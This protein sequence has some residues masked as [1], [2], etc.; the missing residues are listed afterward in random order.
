MK[1]DER[2]GTVLSFFLI[3][4]REQLEGI[5]NKVERASQSRWNSL[6]IILTLWYWGL[7]N[8]NDPFYTIVDKQWACL[9]KVMERLHVAIRHESVSP[10]ALCKGRQSIGCAPF[11]TLHEM[12]TEKHLRE[13]RALTLH[14]GYCV[15][16]LDGSTQ[17]LISNKALEKAYGRPPSTGKQKSAPQASFVA[18]E[19]LNTGWIAKY[20]LSRWDASELALSKELA[21]DLGFGDLLLADRLYFD[22]VWYVD[23]NRRK[24]KFLFRCNCNRHESLTPES[25]EKIKKLRINGNVDC[26]VDLKVKVGSGRYEILENIRYIEVRRQGVETLY[27]ITNMDE[28]ELT[29]TEAV[30]LYRLR[31]EIETN[32]RF[33]KGQDH[34]PAVRSKKE[35][36]VRQEVLLHVLAHNSVR[37]IQSQACI[38]EAATEASLQC[39]VSTVS[40]DPPATPSAKEVNKD[41]GDAWL[42]KARLHGDLLRPVDLQFYRTVETI[43]GYAMQELLF[44]SSS[45][46][47]WEQLLRKIAGLKI[48]AKPGRSYQRHGRKFNKGKRN[49]GNVKAQR[50]RSGKRKKEGKI[51]SS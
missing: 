35:E 11:V 40:T 43:L 20:R 49:K 21:A 14:K 50:N 3:W 41:D 46:L 48:W 36:T 13:H 18:L 45:T 10:T 17:N 7:R 51:E 32:F 5:A 42:P 47:Q 27:F 39:N 19:L 38:A 9:V 26:R 25:R 31:W 22:P 33:F 1:N 4:S 34:L 12:A 44:P 24:V 29:T 2:H 16:A 37:F 8:R 30:E 28:S 23:L 6:A 15:W